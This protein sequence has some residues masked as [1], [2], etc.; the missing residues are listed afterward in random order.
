M[1]LW[2]PTESVPA[3]GPA[4]QAK[5]RDSTPC[6]CSGCR[7]AD[8]TAGGLDPI[9]ARTGL[10]EDHDSFGSQGSVVIAHA[11][12]PLRQ[13]DGESAQRSGSSAVMP[14]TQRWLSSPLDRF[15]P[16]S[17]HVL[18]PQGPSRDRGLPVG[19]LH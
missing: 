10:A 14:L 3:P 17:E 7:T 13:D 1:S 19:R 18:K 2:V 11:K 16:S 15:A 6:L 9:A 5:G 8:R 4:D 12:C